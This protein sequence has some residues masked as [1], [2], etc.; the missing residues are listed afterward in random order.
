MNAGKVNAGSDGHG[1]EGPMVRDGG[2]ADSF[3]MDLF[4]QCL[5]M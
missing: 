4:H 3:A 2:Q 5:L 1:L